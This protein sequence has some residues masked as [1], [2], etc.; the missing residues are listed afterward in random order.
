M[1][2]RLQQATTLGLLLAAAAWALYFFRIGKPV[3][4]AI[5]A[6]LIVFGYALFLGIE[7][8]LLWFVNRDG[9]APAA[10]AWQV[11][12]AWL[13]EV[14]A[15]PRVFCWRQPFRSHAEPDF[16]PPGAS[17]RGVV[18]VHGFVCNRGLW[19]PSMAKLRRLGVPFIAVNLE[20]VFG[21][22]DHYADIIEGAVRRI[23]SA[24]GE[25]PVI[26]AHSMGGL[27]TRAWLAA[28]RADT[29]VHRVITI[30]TP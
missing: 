2:A 15:A 19:N 24:T 13:G 16:L 9:P 23:Q 26:V 28:Y 1:L 18:F 12:K 3:W 30:G 14:M 6:V 17:R 22:I 4:A 29:R 10:T 7:F 11:L 8:M 25:A 5:G 21:S 20:P 27:A